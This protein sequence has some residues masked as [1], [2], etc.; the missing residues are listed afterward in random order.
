MAPT[1]LGGYGALLTLGFLAWTLAGLPLALAPLEAAG[2]IT[3]DVERFAIAGEA[4]PNQASLTI[5]ATLAGTAAT[6]AAIHATRVLHGMH[7]SHYALRHAIDLEFDVIQ[8][9]PTEFVLNLAGDGDVREV[10]GTGLRDWGVRQGPGGARQLV[11]RL[12]AS[13]IPVQCASVTVT[14]MTRIE[15][16]S[17]PVVPLRIVAEPT[18]LFSGYLQLTADPELDLAIREASGITPLDPEH[19][20]EAFRFTAKAGSAEPLAFRFFAEPYIYAV[21]LTAADPELHRVV[22]H[23]FQLNGRLHE[24]SASFTLMAIARVRNPR[25]G[26]L[27]TLWGDAAL[28]DVEPDADWRVRFEQGRYRLV[29][30]RPGE[31]P[32][33]L[34][35]EARMRRAEG[36]RELDFSVAPSAMQPIELTGLKQAA[37]I[38]FAGAARTERVGDRYLSHLPANGQ[39]KLRWRESRREAEGRLFYAAN[40]LGEITIGP[41]LMRH[42]TLWSFQVIQGRVQEI[43]LACDGAGEVTHV[44]GPSVLAWSVEPGTGPTTRR[45]RVR[46]NQTHDTSFELQIQTQTALGNFPQAIDPIRLVPVAATRLGGYL[47][48]I[49]EGAVRLEVTEAGGLSQISPDQFP[50]NDRTRAEFS[51]QPGQVFAY[52]FSGPDYALRVQADH[53]IPE[54]GVSQLLTYHIGETES[55]IEAELEIDIREAPV[56]E[57]ELRVP[58]GYGVARLQAVGLSD[59]SVS[60][61]VGDA[62]V[63]LQLV[64]L[65]PVIG[66]QVIQLR[67][68][69]AH[70]LAPTNWTLPRVEV[71]TARSVRG[72]VGVSADPGL[73]VSATRT[74]GLAETATAFFPKRTRN[75]QASFRISDPVWQATLAIERLAQSIQADV[76]HLFSVG[77]GLAYGSSVMNYSIAGAPIAV[78]NIELSDEYH[79]VEFIGEEIRNWQKTASGFEIQLHTPVAG[80]YSLLATFER[81]FLAQ[82]ET[83]LF[84]G[85]RPLDAQTEQ[86]YTVII[87]AFQFQV[88]PAQVSSGLRPLEPGEVPAE[89]RLLFDAPIL[90][91]YHYTTRP[92]E[93]ELDL[94]PLVQ[95]DTVSQIIDRADITTR[96]SESGQVLT[97]ARYFFKSKAA[98]HLRVGIPPQARL[99]SVTVNGQPVVPIQDGPIYLVPLPPGLDPNT[100]QS[101]ELK[102]AEKSPLPKRLTVSAPW[103][104]APVLLTEWRLEPESGRRLIYRRGSLLPADRPVDETGFG[105]LMR[106][107]GGPLANRAWSNLGGALA[108]VALATL[109]WRLSS[110]EGT[111]RFSGRYWTGLILGIIGCAIAMLLLLDLARLAGTQSV[112]Q[113][114]QLSFLAPIQAG[115]EITTVEVLNLPIERSAWALL[116]LAW[117]GFVGLVFWIYALLQPR[118]FLRSILFA[119]GW[120]F[121]FWVFLRWFNAAPVV[122]YV[123]VGFVL[124]HVIYPAL[125]QLWQLPL[126]PSTG[127]PAHPVTAVPIWIG[128]LFLCLAPS[129]QAASLRTLPPRPTDTAPAESVIQTARV[130]GGF[131]FVTAAIHWRAEEGQTLDLLH[132]PG[133]LTRAVYPQSSLKLV[134]SGPDPNPHHGLLALESGQYDLHLEYQ[135]HV[136]EKD[137]QS[138]FHLPIAPGLINRLRIQLTVADVDVQSPHAVSIV[139]DSDPAAGGTIADLVLEPVPGA[140][141]GW[142]P[143]M[144]DTRAETTVF[145]AELSQLYAPIPGLIEGIHD[146]R[147]RPAQGEIAEVTFGVPEP[148]T[149]TDVVASSVLLWRFDPDDRTLRVTL[150]RPQSDPF[151]LQIRSQIAT[152]PL[153]YQQNIP[154]IF[155]HAAAGQV[156]LLGVATGSEVQLDEV[157]SSSFTAIHLDDFPVSALNAL[158]A[159]VPAVT[160]RR[161][162]R[163]S[164]IDARMDLLASPVKPD[165]RVASH[166]TLSLGEDRLVLAAQLDLAITRTGIFKLSFELPTGLEVETIGGDALSHWTELKTE[167]RRVITLHLHDKTEGEHQFAL[168]LVGPGARATNS[169]VPP[170]LIVREASKQTGQLVLVPEQGLRISVGSRDGVIQLDPLRDGIRQKGVLAFRLLHAQWNLRLNIEPVEAWIQV[171]SLQDVAVTEGQVQVTAHLEYQIENT[172]IRSF[173]VRLPPRPKACDSTGIRSRTIWTR[174]LP[175]TAL[176]EPGLSNSSVVSSAFIPCGLLFTFRW[177]LIPLRLRSGESKPM[178]LIFNAAS[179]PFTQRGV[180][181]CM[182]M[183]FP[184]HSRLPTSRRFPARFGTVQTRFRP[185]MPS[186]WSKPTFNS[187]SGSNGMKR[188]DSFPPVSRV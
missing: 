44:E 181:R 138:G 56:R 59:Y 129:T 95:G 30:D 187:Q 177:L 6:E 20:P 2:V 17:Q 106:L 10:T 100:V 149:I 148:L 94:K 23:D 69:Q 109:V 113:F 7:A 52:R 68:E 63:A 41:G 131:V 26:S 152:R 83:L 21:Q 184:P 18:S 168:T 4:G 66:R 144:R 29:F 57:L 8:G 60:E 77:E 108:L 139:L 45:L 121:W 97:D 72:H 91:A 116:A 173:R 103:L 39:V 163:Y 38:Q 75:I 141:V 98:P 132:S 166:E 67:L 112:N 105:G 174:E 115:G 31:Y 28:T 137:G 49:N 130:E 92:F 51:E 160:L 47:R 134:P 14:A 110:R 15:D 82:G 58:P 178:T 162:F 32:V 111:W 9:A 84:T 25:G 153:P 37:E 11:M 46:L 183:P 73:R 35:F 13:T 81:P 171:S 155:V 61:P 42:T 151:Q 125:R 146:I 128:A 185:P 172:G 36:W 22:L 40:A 164:D 55:V 180:S 150:T 123:G 157:D 126:H 33:R 1:H 136:V 19:L 85:A 176:P 80:T 24:T 71:T 74:D 93:L 124:I 101:L 104:F 43:E 169:W 86:G 5:Q 62:D 167:D 118:G 88:E 3:S 102:L 133:V 179:S 117:P 119:L 145:Y 135:T 96:I 114:T 170:R 142:I 48:V 79:N 188:H 50:R 165:I 90:G 154:L 107:F 65:D 127:N 175:P 143:R 120:L 16:L 12:I 186:V 99:W 64:Y 182:S 87:S 156:G 89:Y 53:I 158:A 78:F 54:L 27:D 159:R 161:A 76:F 34:H 122:I 140:W 70:R 147:F